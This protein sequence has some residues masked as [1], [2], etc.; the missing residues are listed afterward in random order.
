MSFLEQYNKWIDKADKATIEELI[1]IKDNNSEI[2][3][4][5]YQVLNFGT[6]GLR[7][8]MAA[9]TNRMNKY[10]IGQATKALAQVILEEKRQDEGVAIAYDCRINSKAFAKHCASIFAS[11]GI[12]VYIFDDLRP[13]PELSFA[14]RYLKTVSGVNVTASHNPKEYNGY[15]VYWDEGSQIL[16]N[17][18]LRVQEK[19][20]AIDLFDNKGIMAFEEGIEKGLI[21]IIGDEIDEEYSKQ[22]LAL[23]LND[24]NVNK[25]INIVYT[26]FN[27]TGIKFIPDILRKRGFNNI[28]LVKEQE[29]PDGNFP[30]LPYPNPEESKNFEYALKY[31][32]KNN[33]DIILAS[34]PDADRIAIMIKDNGDNYIP[35]NGN[36]TGILLINYILSQRSKQGLNKSNDVM[37]K[38]IVTGDMGIE[39]SKNFK[40]STMETLTGFKHICGLANEFEKTKQYNYVFGFEESIG[41]CPETFCRDKDA[42]S[43]AML[44]CEMCGYY[45]AQNKTMYQVLY[46]LYEKYGYYKETQFA[47]FYKGLEGAVI[48]ESVMKEYRRNY[49]KELANTKLIQKIDYLNDNTGIP[50]SNVLKYRFEDGSW[51]AIRPSGTEPKLK[52]YIYTIDKNEKVSLDKLNKFESE[53][54]QILK[55]IERSII[56][57]K[58]IS[59]R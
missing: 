8:I 39:I 14:I 15:K 19:I 25:N 51:Y 57:D 1:A 41:Y 6:A 59:G 55:N 36:Q 49:P 38:T 32:V 58:N 5:F 4:R 30:T 35:L 20:K 47:I 52:I 50:K 40:V 46:E 45:M 44:L 28:V 42:V 3:D 43:T 12:K 16:D 54:K 48:K 29:H 2:E 27:G 21:N 7:G 11:N 10:V 9:G 37:V 31:A 17:I 23:K 24:V 53:L 34:D 56:N 22:V 26:P 18:A 33:A 13:T